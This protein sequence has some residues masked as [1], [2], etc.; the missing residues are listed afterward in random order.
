MEREGASSSALRTTLEARASAYGPEDPELPGVPLGTP[1]SDPKQTS[2][3]ERTYKHAPKMK[4]KTKHVGAILVVALAQGDA[5][6]RHTPAGGH[7]E[8]D[9]KSQFKC[10]DPRWL[11][12]IYADWC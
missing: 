3:W 9:G 12:T 2:A 11:E 7:P 10:A 5:R 4:H 6:H 1:G 8:K